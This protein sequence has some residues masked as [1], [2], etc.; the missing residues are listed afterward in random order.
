[1]A[2][3]ADNAGPYSV[4]YRRPPLHSRFKPGQSGN[5]TGHRKPRKAPRDLLDDLLAEK[6]AVT[7]QGTSKRVT[8]LELILRQLVNRS[9]S[10][11][12]RLMRMLLDMLARSVPEGSG[13]ILAPED[14]AIIADLMASMGVKGPGNGS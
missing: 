9:A 11:D 4:G 12:A 14:E 5:P 13:D 6:V 2:D 8:K 1:M 3:G 10:G 7:E